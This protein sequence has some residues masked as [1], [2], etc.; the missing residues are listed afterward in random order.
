M[1]TAK[2]ERLT[3]AQALLRFLAVQYSERDGYEQRLI[4]GVWGIF[5]HGNVAGLGQALQ[6]EGA[7]L[8]MPYYRAQNEQAQVHLAAAYAKHQRRLAT[9]ACTASVGPGSSNMLTGAALATINRLPVLLLPSDFFANRLPDPVLQQLEHPSEHDSSINDCFRPV[10]RFYSRI[11]RP[12]QLLHALPEAMRV[13]TD[14]AETG[15]VVLSLPQ[16]VQTEAYAFP[17][18]LF[19]KRS[20]LVRRPPADARSLEVAVALLRRAARPLIICGGGVKYSD[21]SQALADFAERFSIPIAET[22]AGKGAVPWQHPLN[23]GAVGALGVTSANSLADEADLIL[24]VGTRLG[25]FTTGSKSMFAPDAALIGLNICPMDAHKLFALA[26]VADARCALEQLQQALQGMTLPCQGR[27]QEIIRRKQAW[28]AH[29]DTVLRVQDSQDLAQAEVIGMV[30]QI[31]GADATVINAAGSMPGDLL[32]LWRTQSPQ[33]YHVE[34]GYS[35]MGYEIPAGLG[36][37]LADPQGSVV[38]MVGDGSYLMMN[39]EIVTAVAEG[40][41]VCIVLVDNHGFQSIHG[42]QRSCGGA[43]FGNELR[44]RNPESQQ[45]DGAYV[46]IDF[47]AHARAMGAHSVYVDDEASLRQALEHAQHSSG[48]Q[49]VVVRVNPE[50]RL[51]GYAFGGWWDTPIAEQSTRLEVQQAGATYQQAKEQQYAVRLPTAAHSP[52]PADDSDDDSND[53]SNA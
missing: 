44:Y 15:A 22:Q 35:C 38:V 8:A 20:W 4:R 18:T 27:Y 23:V 50:K 52:E 25:D 48:V 2:T 26:L 5:G 17:S 37:K 3:V 40:I 39:S 9:W 21:A 14:P 53:D 49:V 29:V 6:E 16:D 46:P 33:G 10:S 43:S 7:Q 19:A 32:K 41:D 1:T 51:G 45:L 28:D 47:A 42:L 13:L 36:V 12:E 34:Y 24:A 11:S 31:F 30:N